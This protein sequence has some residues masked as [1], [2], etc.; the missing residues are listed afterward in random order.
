M[1]EIPAAPKGMPIAW[2]GHYY[3]RA[4]E[5]LISLGMDKLDEIRQQTLSED[6]SAQ[7]VSEAEF[8]DLDE[9][10]LAMAREAFAKKYA[11]R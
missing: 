8:S 10:A 5:S 4:G 7:I 9:K 11:N 2:S 6:W 3:A 1:F